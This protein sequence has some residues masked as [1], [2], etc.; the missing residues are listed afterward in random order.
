MSIFSLP[1]GTGDRS[2]NIVAMLRASFAR[3]R[4]EPRRRLAEQQAIALLQSIE[5]GALDD[6]G[7][8]AHPAERPQ[9]A[10]GRGRMEIGP[11][12]AVYLPYSGRSGVNDAPER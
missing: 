5:P 12:L 2:G 10:T 7:T 1:A 11:M 3:W 8:A 4:E 9:P 6:V